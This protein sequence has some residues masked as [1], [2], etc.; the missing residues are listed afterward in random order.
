[1]ERPL[2]F[3]AARDRPVVAA[4]ERDL[5]RRFGSDCR[6]VTGYTPASG[7]ATL[8]ALAGEGAPVA[9]LI[10]DREMEGM[11]GVDFLAKAHALHPHAKR[12]L[13]VERDYTAAN[14]IVPA[15]IL[16]KIDYHLVRPWYPE[17]ALYPA[18]SEFLA[19]WADSREPRFKMF[20]LVGPEPSA[21]GHEIRDLLSRIAT[22]YVYYAQESEEGRR[23]LAEIGHEGER[24]PVAVRHDGKVLVDPSD[25]ELIEAIGG[26]TRLGTGLHDLVIVG[27]GPAGL[28]S[29]RNSLIAG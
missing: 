26:G 29:A 18:I 15:M 7:L 24:V 3:I 13:L 19:D 2:F 20:R 27:A 5:A 10:A 8:E 17:E 22:P 23:L 25:A 4:L 28:A 11:A 6:I 14:P 16:G 9:L 21:R 12:I 1:M